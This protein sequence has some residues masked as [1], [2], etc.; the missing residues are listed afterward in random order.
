MQYV[1]AMQNPQIRSAGKHKR[2]GR[3]LFADV[4]GDVGYGFGSVFGWKGDSD[5]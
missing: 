2:L 5:R 3:S 1:S 4:V